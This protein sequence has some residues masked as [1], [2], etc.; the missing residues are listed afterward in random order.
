MQASVSSISDYVE[1]TLLG[2]NLTL[3]GVASLGRPAKGALHFAKQAADDLVEKL[4]PYAPCAI[5]VPLESQLAPQPG[6]AVIEVDLPRVAFARAATEFFV[7]KKP[8]SIA[9]SAI[10]GNNVTL[11]KGVVIGH[12]CVIGDDV[13]IGDN[14]ELRHHVVIANRAVIGQRC[15]IKSHAVLGEEGFGI[16]YDRNENTVRIPH[17]SNILIEDDVEIGCGS[18]VCQGTLE[19]TIVRR[20]TKIDDH[21]HVGHNVDVGAQSII[22]ACA[23]IGGSVK[24]GSHAWL[25]LNANIMNGFSL[26][27][28][29][30]AGIG[31]NVVKSL[32]GGV[33]VAGVPAKL[34]RQR[35]TL[36]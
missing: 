25:G 23:C 15:L 8:A 21:V 27:D 26:G 13:T 6:V 4:K 31:A 33:V 19:P 14:T 35:D 16:A 20:G 36:D 10:I 11:G 9:P 3:T 12:Y 30:L 17:F 1:G 34:V 28:R 7:P 2:E 29:A 5:L 24:I 32:D 22:T 18:T